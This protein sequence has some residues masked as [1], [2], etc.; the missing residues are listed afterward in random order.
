MTTIK[1]ILRQYDEMQQ[2]YLRLQIEL[3]EKFNDENFILR[4]ISASELN[5][6]IEH[7]SILSTM[8]DI[9]T[10]HPSKKITI[11]VCGVKEFCRKNRNVGRKSVEKALTELQVLLNVDNRMI[12][13]AADLN[14][15]VHQFAKSIGD[16]P[17]RWV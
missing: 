2:T 5:N 3:T 9:K 15:T 1:N 11:L 6:Q 4:V 17:L 13:T 8:N 12:E 10:E 14:I 7:K 16:I